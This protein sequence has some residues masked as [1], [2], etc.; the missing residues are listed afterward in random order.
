M[1]TLTTS[2]GAAARSRLARVLRNKFVAG[3]IILI[4]IVLTVKGLWWLFDY[5]DGLA[6]PLAVRMVGRTIWGLGIVITVLVVFLAGLL[7]SAGPLKKVLDGIEDFLDDVPLVGT[8]YGTTKKV[9]S[10]FG[11]P[12]TQNAFQ[13][14]VLAQL[15][16]RTTPGFLTGTFTLQRR[17]GERY[18][19]CTVYV[20]TNHLYVGDV[21]VLPMEDV[22][23]TDLS[24][25][26]GVSL[27]LSAGASVPTV[28]GE[29]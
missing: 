18:T 23:E 8:V 4:P 13:R 22:I 15:P 16:G 20:P 24:V 27:I 2:A 11:N 6:Q 9:L 3:L 12:D 1:S 7:F 17:S 28:V 19:L 25:E 14:F 29:R 10:G 26:D 5:A 21:V